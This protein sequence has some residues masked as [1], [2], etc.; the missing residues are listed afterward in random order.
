MQNKSAAAEG[1]PI[2]LSRRRFLGAIIVPLATIQ[3]SAACTPLQKRSSPSP[4]SRVRGMT[5]AYYRRTLAPR[6]IP[7]AADKPRISCTIGERMWQ[8]RWGGMDFR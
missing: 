5:S 2:I 4:S 8:Q 3:L 6:V 1:A 7:A